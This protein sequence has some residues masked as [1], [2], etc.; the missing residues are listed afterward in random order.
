MEV[1]VSPTVADRAGPVRWPKFRPGDLVVAQ[2]GY[3]T[4]FEVICVQE[5]GMLRVRG[6]NWAPGYSA[7]VAADELRPTTALLHR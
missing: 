3:P 2:G 1:T 5:D 7:L 4:L 6:L